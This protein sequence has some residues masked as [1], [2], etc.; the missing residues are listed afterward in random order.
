VAG[1]VGVDDVLQEA[2]LAAAQRHQHVRGDTQQS[3]VICLRL[4]VMQTLADIH[5]RHLGAQMRDAKRD[6]ATRLADRSELTAMSLAATL[7]GHLTSPTLAARRG[8]MAQRLRA[9]LETMD[10]VDRE[11]LALRHFEELSNSEVAEELEIE[12][13]A[14]SIRYVRALRRLKEIVSAMP[15]FAEVARFGL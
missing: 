6:R 14:A 3:L 1:R 2:Y 15:D 13:K 4:I 12:P 7:M 11:V 10:A 9:T 5:R 8:E